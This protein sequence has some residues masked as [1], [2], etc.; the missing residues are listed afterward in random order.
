MMTLLLAES[1]GVAGHCRAGDSVLSVCPLVFLSLVKRPVRNRVG[2]DPMIF[3][4]LNYF[5]KAPL[6]NTTVGSSFHPL[7]HHNGIKLQQEFYSKPY[8]HCSKYRHKMLS[9]RHVVLPSGSP[10]LSEQ[11]RDIPPCHVLI[12]APQET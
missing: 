6:L 9:L 12:P 1:G 5:P 3:S 10:D 2:H 8:P 4:N 7:I 11:R